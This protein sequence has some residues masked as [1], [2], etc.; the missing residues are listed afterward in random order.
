MAMTKQRK[1]SHVDEVSDFKTAPPPRLSFCTIPIL[2]IVL[3]FL[4]VVMLGALAVVLFRGYDQLEANSPHCSKED[5]QSAALFREGAME[6]K[7]RL[8]KSLP[9]KSLSMSWDVRTLSLLSENQIRMRLALIPTMD[10]GEATDARELALVTRWATLNPKGAS[11][12]A[13]QAVLCGADESLLREAVSRW[14]AVDPASAA[15]W[16]ASLASPGLRDLAVASAYK[17]WS[18]KNR[19]ESL[20]ALPDLTGSA[21]RAAAW[22]GVSQ[23]IFG[24]DAKKSPAI[25]MQLPGP[26]REKALVQMFGPWIRRD[27]AAVAEWLCTQPMEIQLPLAARIAAEWARRDPSSALAWSGAASSAT[28]AAPHLPSGPV[29]RRAMDAAV[30]SFVT[31]DPESAAIW[32]AS[33]RGRAFFRERVG[34]VVSSWTS[35]DPMAAAA[36][37]STISPGS[38]RE[39]AVGALSSTWARS[40]PAGALQWIQRISGSSDRNIALAAFGRTLAPSDPEGAAYWSSQITEMTLR[41]ATLAKVVSVWKTINP[42]AAERFVQTAPSAVFLRRK[43]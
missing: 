19:G 35:I 12:Y 2:K 7:V 42:G 39:S 16:A 10:P 20:A 30:T 27:P 26:L 28:L 18:S 36:W 33:E 15:L 11:I 13:Y 3:L 40:D 37:A 5:F 43:K 4:A 17:V 6:A 24:P 29:Q 14:A 38:D 32:I 41:E 34:A 23:T 21:A 25:V 1:I 31:S 22:M 9:Q 8:L